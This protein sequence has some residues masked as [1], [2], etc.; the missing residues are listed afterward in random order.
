M[1]EY[2]KKAPINSVN[3]I[4]EKIKDD[5]GKLMT[6]QYGNYFCHSLVRCI[7]IE[8]RLKVL[9]ALTPHFVNI[10][11]D[12]NGTHSMQRIIELVS[13]DTEKMIIFNAISK[14]I[15]HLAFHAKGNYV[16]LGVL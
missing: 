13:E 7:G 6:S 4:I 9:K 12:A 16:L 8:Q 1:Q 5:F 11:C 2:L 3:L 10:S 15:L 14:R